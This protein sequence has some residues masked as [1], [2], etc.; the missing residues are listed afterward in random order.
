VVGYPDV[1]GREAILRVHSRGKPLGPDVDLKII[2]QTT[3]GFTGA[4]LENLLNEAALLAARK[5]AK[6]IVESDIE[7]ATIKVV[8]GVEKKSRVISDK[9]KLITSYHEAGHAI[10]SYFLPTQDEVHQISI[11]PRG[12][13][14]GYTMYRPADDQSHVSRQQLK[15][16]ICS[17]LG[18]RVAEALTQSDICTGAS[19]DLQRATELAQKMIMKYGMSEKLGPI[20]Y[21]KHQEEVFLGRDFNSTQTYSDKIAA[22]IDAEIRALVEGQYKHAE[23]ILTAHMD[24]LHEIAK[25][26]FEHEKMDADTF[27]QAMGEQPAS[28]Q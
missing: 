17:L 27:R 8:M 3:A 18:G 4:D 6:A 14:A 15:E 16:Q 22:E 7:E 13:A 2:A 1:K 10:V 25:Y 20:V 12:M 19:N 26:L 5:Q 11:I 28:E 24:K 21:G 9:D 23:E